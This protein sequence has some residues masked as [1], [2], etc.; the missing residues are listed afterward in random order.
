MINK[1][2]KWYD[3]LI[4]MFLLLFVIILVF[5]YLLLFY[6]PKV[7]IFFIIQECVLGIPII[8][9]Y[10]EKYLIL[11]YFFII[12]RVS[13][14]FNHEFSYDTEK[15]NKLKNKKS[16]NCFMPHGI[17]PLTMGFYDIEKNELQNKVLL[18]E[19]FTNNILKKI[20]IPLKIIPSDKKKISNKI[21]NKNIS[22]Y[23]GGA[24]EFF[25]TNPKT[26]TLFIKKRKGIFKLAMKHNTPI[27]PFYTFGITQLYDKYMIGDM[28]I[29]PKKVKLLTVCGKYITPR[30][31]DTVRKIRKRYI[32]EVKRI[33]YKYR[34]IYKKEWCDKKLIIY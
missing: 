22:I 9:K 20:M 29:F 26:E 21:K 4:M 23:I 5:F 6:F 15:P 14:Y 32:R 24:H 3:K 27:L 8:K 10:F 31:D 17:C 34:S 28:L 33:F 30:K 1:K 25:S 2:E 18:K 13:I 16:I 11:I 12:K 19:L 7:R